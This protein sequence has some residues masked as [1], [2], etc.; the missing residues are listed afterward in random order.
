MKAAAEW[1]AGEYEFGQRAELTLAVTNDSKHPILVRGSVLNFRK[2]NKKLR[3][4]HSMVIDPSER[5]VLKRLSVRI[6]PW[7]EKAG[8]TATLSITF[9]SKKGPNWEGQT[10][11]MFPQDPALTITDAS[12]TGRKIFISHSNSDR[13]NAI[14][15]EAARIVKKAGFE[16]YVSEK[17]LRLG[18]DLWEKILDQILHCDGLIFLLT[19]DGAKSC[20]MREELGY[21]RMCNEM[22]DGE[23]VKI[24]PIVEKGVDPSGSFKGKEYK[25]IDLGKVRPPTEQIADIILDSFVGRLDQT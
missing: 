11:R 6:G 14:V 16:P 13:D 5:E 9:E 3:E 25:E 18:D 12:P 7:A 17:D 15:E 21:A 22:K 2:T 24:V 4:T 8:A 23:A 20:D 1:D 10:T 19:K